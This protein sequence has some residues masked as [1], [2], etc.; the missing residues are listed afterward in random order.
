ME[1]KDRQDGFTL[2]ELLVVIGIMSLLAAGIAVVGSKVRQGAQIKATKTTMSLLCSALCEYQN[3]K[4]I[5]SG[6]AFPV[7]PELT[8][9]DLHV[10]GPPAEFG[11][12]YAINNYLPQVST[13]NIHSEQHNTFTWKDDLQP[14][15]RRYALTTIE[16]IYA[17]MEDVP[18]CRAILEK[19]PQD[20]VVNADNDS[21][22]ILD[23]SGN[24]I[25]AKALLE[26]NDAWGHPLWYTVR[27]A[28]QPNP[29]P[30][31]SGVVLDNFPMTVSAGPDGLFGTEDDIT[32]SGK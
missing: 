3:V 17:V 11:L 26:V 7:E 16:F 6:F 21:M 2:V 9:F 19:L 1:S 28:I 5:G 32:S 23:P 13:T 4:D 12:I 20:R 24:I 30:L 8:G 22:S 25:A 10:A 27:G 31:A 29:Q 14:D 18:Q 15:E